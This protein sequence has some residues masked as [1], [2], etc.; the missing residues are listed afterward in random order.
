[1]HRKFSSEAVNA[2]EGEEHNPVIKASTKLMIWCTSGRLYAKRI[3]MVLHRDRL[4][5]EYHDGK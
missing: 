4:Y 1:M 2:V 5:Y 3:V